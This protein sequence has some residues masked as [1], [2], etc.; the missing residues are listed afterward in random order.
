V[1]GI[2]VGADHTYLYLQGPAGL[3][4]ASGA[5]TVE[6]GPD[7][8]T[9]PFFSG[10]LVGFVSNPP[11]GPGAV[12]GTLPGGPGNRQVGKAFAGAA[13][14]VEIAEITSAVSNCDYGG[15]LAI[16]NPTPA[17]G[18]CYNSNSFA[19]TLLNDVGLSTYFGSTGFTPGWG[20][21]VPGLNTVPGQN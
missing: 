1:G 14:C 11:G 13:A 4:P 7:F 18:P 20:Y 5:E 12:P 15:S 9:I 3:L 19:F 10:Y 17:L 21:T 6:S 8:S 2:A 16:Y